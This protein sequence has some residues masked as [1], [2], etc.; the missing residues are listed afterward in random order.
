MT[1]RLSKRPTLGY[2]NVSGQEQQMTSRVFFPV[3]LP[4]SRS[5]RDLSSANRYGAIHFVISSRN[6]PSLM[7][8]PAMLE[9]RQNL[10]DFDPAKDYLSWSGGDPLAML[11]VGAVLAENGVRDVKFLRYDRDRGTDGRRTGGGF[12]TPITVRLR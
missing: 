11:L 5:D 12:Y 2:D 1:L 4:A 8:G 10:C 3:E 9:A 7:P 6:T